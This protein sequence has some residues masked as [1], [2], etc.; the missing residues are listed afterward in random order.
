MSFFDDIKQAF[1][2]VPKPSGKVKPCAYLC[3][4]NIDPVCSRR[5]A[6]PIDHG[7]QLAHVCEHHLASGVCHLRCAKCMATCTRPVGDHVEPN[8]EHWCAWHAPAPDPVCI[9]VDLKVT[10]VTMLTPGGKVYE[11][12][13]GT[14]LM[15]KNETVLPA[16][17][18]EKLKALA[19]QDEAWFQTTP[20]WKPLSV[21][22]AERKAAEAV[23]HC[24]VATPQDLRARRIV[25][26]E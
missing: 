12:G 22:E 2:T 1:G 13:A 14:L 6:H 8:A 3:S 17:V 26:E 4:L 16:A 9:P 15:H 25:V 10:D 23:K 20:G 18:A 7:L 19:A 24:E 5:C 21:R 11:F